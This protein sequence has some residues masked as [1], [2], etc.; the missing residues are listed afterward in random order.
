MLSEVYRDITDPE[1]RKGY[2]ITKVKC[3]DL[4]FEVCCIDVVALLSHYKE[5]TL[6]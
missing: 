4:C 3:N 5:K 1:V 6:F 2:A